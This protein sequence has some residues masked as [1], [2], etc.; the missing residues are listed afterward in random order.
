MKKTPHNTGF[1]SGGGI[2]TVDCRWK[3]LEFQRAAFYNIGFPIF[4]Q[5]SK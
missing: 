1:A 3:R 5:R 4:D 2:H